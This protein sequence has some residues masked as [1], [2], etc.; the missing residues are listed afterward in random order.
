MAMSDRPL[1]LCIDLQPVLL[2]A[3]PDGVDVL[4]RCCLAVEA[5]RGFGLP[6]LFTEQVPS[7]LGPIAPELLTLANLPAII[8]KEE[9][10]A[11]GNV[12]VQ[13]AVRDAQVT[14]VI[15]CGIE[16]PVCVYQTALD[17]LAMG[18]QVTL[19]SDCLGCRRP[20][21][22]AAALRHLERLGGQLLPCETVFY[23]LLHSALHPFFR[24]YNELVKR[25]A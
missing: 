23:G 16:T 15:L 21:D 18:L 6:V 1:L 25:Y 14:D 17:A 20:A 12:A 2:K 10:S 11:L 24:D 8:A 7:K 4:R 5:A 13:D 22:A 3:I 9:F 19:L